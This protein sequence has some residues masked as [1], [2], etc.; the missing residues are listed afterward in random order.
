MHVR[1]SE[2]TKSK[3]TSNNS[4]L[5][6]RPLACGKQKNVCML[7]RRQA[8]KLGEASM[9]KKNTRKATLDNHIEKMCNG[10]VRRAD[11]ARRRQ[12]LRTPSGDIQ[13]EHAIILFLT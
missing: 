2:T 9:L 11:G 12:D 1:L 10:Q 7:V 3:Q 13:L 4:K 8:G 6:Y 5:L